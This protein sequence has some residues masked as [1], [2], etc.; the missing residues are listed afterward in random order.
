MAKK[1]DFRKRGY[2]CA[3]A[4]RPR[5]FG[6][7]HI[8][9]DLHFC[10]DGN[11]VYNAE[12]EKD[13]LYMAQPCIYTDTRFDTEKGM[14]Y[15]HSTYVYFSRRNFDKLRRQSEWGKPNRTPRD[16]GELPITLK[17]CIRK[18]RGIKGIPKG[19]AIEFANHWYY[20][21]SD[22]IPAY[23]YIHNGKDA[24]FIPDYQVNDDCYKARFTSDEWANELTDK[25][26]E[27]GFLVQ[28]WN[29][30]P[31]FIYGEGEGEIAVAYGFNKKI[32]FSTG[33]NDFRGYSNGCESVLYDYRNYFDKWS[34]ALGIKKTTPIDEIVR[35]LKDETIKD[36]YPFDSED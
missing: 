24:D 4:W 33:K 28:V 21:K 19:T 9:G 23:V 11:F 10:S 22:N 27:A 35:Q 34:K 8:D 20:P 17:S 13:K 15:Y 36:A 30:N 6:L 1:I 32:G 2:R 16:W 12:T 3:K 26:R 7:I 25:L 31:G 29:E 5:H 18:V 14:N